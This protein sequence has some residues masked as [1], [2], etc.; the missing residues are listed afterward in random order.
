[1]NS[2]DLPQ[3][4]AKLVASGYRPA[5][6]WSVWMSAEGRRSQSLRRMAM[7]APSYANILQE[8]TEFDKDESQAWDVFY[9]DNWA[10]IEWDASSRKWRIN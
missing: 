4:T 5:L 2:D 1:M 9:S 10:S 6:R 8:Y 7:H 3:F